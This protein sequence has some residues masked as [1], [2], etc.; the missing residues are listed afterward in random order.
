VLKTKPAITLA[1]EGYAKQVSLATLSF[2]LCINVLH[3]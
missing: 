2:L 1:P 3:W